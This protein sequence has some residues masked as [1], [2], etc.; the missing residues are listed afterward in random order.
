[1]KVE[2]IA[3]RYKKDK[4][5]R[6]GINPYTLE[7][8]GDFSKSKEETYELIKRERKDGYV[9]GIQEIEHYKEN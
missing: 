3:F 9:Y 7:Y 6:D 8:L 2:Y 4:R 5:F 1:M